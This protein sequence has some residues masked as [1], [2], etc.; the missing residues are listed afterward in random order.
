M[1]ILEIVPQVILDFQ[2]LVVIVDS[3]VSPVTLVSQVYQ[4][5][6]V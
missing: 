1:V 3:Q 5:T 4:A 6:Q 2:V